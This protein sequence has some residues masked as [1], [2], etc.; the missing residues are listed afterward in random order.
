MNIP[1]RILRARLDDIPGQRPAPSFRDEDTR[2]RILDCA[3]QLM[4]HHGRGA[5]RLT[6]FALAMR[7]SAQTI[8]RHFVDLDCVLAQ[9][10]TRHLQAIVRALGEIPRDTPDRARAHRA[11]YL[12]A[13][14]FLGAP[15][16]AHLLLIRDRHLLP[17]D[18][19]EPLE[20]HRA[21]IG[22]ILAGAHAK[23]ALALLDMPELDA[24]DIEAALGAIARGAAIGAIAHEAPAPRQ[25]AARPAYRAAEPL[26]PLDHPSVPDLNDAKRPP[27]GP[28]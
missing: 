17:P 26:R 6:D 28:H 19:R 21:S 23:A 16:E 12:A 11:A 5:I 3:Q 14:R 18:L 8:R 9:I 13:T 27:M 1:A 7:M 4:A 25:A 20:A 15:T 24:T 2:T 10:L 22:E